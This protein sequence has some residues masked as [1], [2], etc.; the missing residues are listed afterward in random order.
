MKRP[1]SPAWSSKPRWLGSN[2][3]PVREQGLQ[4]IPRG[5]PMND[6]LGVVGAVLL[7][8]GAV[9]QLIPQI[10]GRDAVLGWPGGLVLISGGACFVLAQHRAAG[11][12]GTFALPP[13]D[14]VRTS[15]RRICLLGP[16]LVLVGTH[17]PVRLTTDDTPPI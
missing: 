2:L 15:L 12:H 1:R 17:E 11:R 3:M 10:S 14:P 4:S 6:R 5:N 7:G 9:L 16:P 13:T 8:L